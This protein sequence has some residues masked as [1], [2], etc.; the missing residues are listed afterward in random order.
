MIINVILG[1]VTVWNKGV[2]SVVGGLPG[3]MD[4]EKLFKNSITIE[5]ENEHTEVTE[6][7]LQGELVHRS[8]NMILKKGLLAT[9]EQSSF[10]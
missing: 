10:L 5:N 2:P 1:G 6:Y 4:T 7:W 9:G 3:E 8:V